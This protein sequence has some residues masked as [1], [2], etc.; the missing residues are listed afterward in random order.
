MKKSA[1]FVLLLFV[2]FAHYTVSAQEDIKA[3]HN[4][5]FLCINNMEKEPQNAFQFC[6]DY[7]QKYPDD[8]ER[9][10]KFARQWMTAYGKILVYLN[11][12][13]MSLSS[14]PKQNWMIYEPDLDKKISNIS[15]QDKSHKIEIERKY[16]SPLEDKYLK[17]AE[18]VYPTAEKISMD[19][20]KNWRFLSQPEYNLPNGEPKWWTG[21]ADTILQ[22]EIV[23]DQCCYLLSKTF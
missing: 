21:Y 2:T 4:A 10:V 11:S 8:D 12:V 20:V 23:T 13:Q 7:L 5:Y 22:T 16:T 17:K 3:K 18:A 9:L 15:V 19:L 1:A 14:D 6:S